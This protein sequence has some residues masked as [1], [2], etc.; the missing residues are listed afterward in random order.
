MMKAY[1][2][3]EE[4]ELMFDEMVIAPALEVMEEERAKEEE[5]LAANREW[6]ANPANWDSEI[7]SDIY[8]DVYGVR[9]RW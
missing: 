2:V 4:M 9:P 8:K 5:L 1:T 7:Y 3:Q 6:L